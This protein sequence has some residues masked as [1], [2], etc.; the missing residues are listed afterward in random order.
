MSILFTPK[1]LRFL[2]NFINNILFNRVAERFE[3]VN[4]SMAEHFLK[5]TPLI[6]SKFK[7]VQHT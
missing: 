2:R 4:P 5:Q 7:C 3:T 1:I 6:K